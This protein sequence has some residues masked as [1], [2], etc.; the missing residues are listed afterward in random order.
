MISFSNQVKQELCTTITDRDKAYACLYGMLLFA[1]QLRQ[2]EILMQSESEAFYELMPRLFRQVFG[3]RVQPRMETGQHGTLYSVSLTDPEQVRI[4]LE[5]YHII[6]PERPLEMTNVVTNSLGSFTA[7]AFLSCG[8]MTDPNKEYHLEFV[9]PCAQLEEPFSQ[10]LLAIGVNAKTVLRKG[11]PV[12]Y[13]KHSEQIEDLLTFMGAQQGTIDFINIEILK[14][15]RNKANRISNCDIANINKVMLAAE[16]QIKD[17]L[18]I[19]ER[20]GL[21]ALSPDLQ[22]MALLRMDNPELSLKELGELLD[23]PIGRSGVNHRL[24]RLQVL[25]DSLRTQS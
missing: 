25:A 20:M 1:R 11:M 19:D 17:I 23:P 22:Q 21:D 13:L 6:L 18:L 4:V 12:V 24:K 14:N 10:I 15:V 16:R 9:L 3:D 2:D 8:S 5:Q 7:G